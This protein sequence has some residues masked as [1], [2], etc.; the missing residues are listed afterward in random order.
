MTS[1]PK[2][3]K[4]ILELI[5]LANAERGNKDIVEEILQLEQQG[6]NGSR[7]SKHVL[8]RINM[9]FQK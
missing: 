5:A 8:E 1:N 6:K 9:I 7:F 4:H 2:I 3:S